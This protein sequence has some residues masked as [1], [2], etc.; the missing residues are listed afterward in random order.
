MSKF[1][2]FLTVPEMAAKA[3]E[4]GFDGIDLCVRPGAHVL[5][6]RV[7]EDLP[8]AAEI[9]RKSGLDLPMITAAIV[10]VTSPHAEKMLKTAASLDIRYYRWGGF[11]YDRGR[12]IPE[13][14]EALKGRVRELADMNRHYKVC[15]MYHLHSGL[16]LVG[17][18][19]WDL[20]LL[21]REFDSKYVG[22]NYDIGHATVE[23]GYGGW[24]NSFRLTAPYVRGIAI[25]DFK[26]GQNSSGQWVPQ[27]SALG[28]GMV[29]F[30]EFLPMVKSAGFSGPVQLH[31]EYPLGGIEVGAAQI[32][33]PV[34]TGFAAMRRDLALLRRWFADAQL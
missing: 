28:E 3:A 13:Q 22:V 6:E 32:K 23:G 33:I 9:I 4:L 16:G 31:F 17:A 7:A 21:L 24:R 11:S 26:W 14:I 27:W 2:Q 30:R 29:N 25:K 8:R 20:W 15:A 5:P 12:S 19:V 10:D 1:L 18:S 34:E